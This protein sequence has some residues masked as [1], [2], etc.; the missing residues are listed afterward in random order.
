MDVPQPSNQS[1]FLSTGPHG[2]RARMRGRLLADPAALADYEIIEMLLFLGIARRDTKPQAKGLINTFGDLRRA[3][4]AAPEALR[5]AGLPAPA[6]DVFAL[7]VDA[8]EQLAGA[9]QR[10]PET[11]PDVAAMALYL[12]DPARPRR[13]GWSVLLLGSRNRLVGDE[14]CDGADADAIGA[15]LLREALGRHATGAILI[16]GTAS[17]AEVT[18]ADRA[19]FFAIQAN[20]AALS[21]QLHDL[22][23]MDTARRWVSLVGARGSC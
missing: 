19:V 2:H 14:A 15:R 23:V 7:V 1:P 6:A 17:H 21:I 12:T 5:G 11:L 4:T 22:V 8:A 20:A 10:Q 3:M 16:R 18:N 9:E 13:M